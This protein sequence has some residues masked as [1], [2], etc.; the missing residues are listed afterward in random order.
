MDKANEIYMH[1]CACICIYAHSYIYHHQLCRS[2]VKASQAI[3]SVVKMQKIQ[4][5]QKWNIIQYPQIQLFICDK[6]Q[7]QVAENQYK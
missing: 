6:S 7:L 2:A 5:E 3:S 4:G 1:L